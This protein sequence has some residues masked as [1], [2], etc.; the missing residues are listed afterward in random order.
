MA[1]FGGGRKRRG[2]GANA[3]HPRFGSEE[4]RAFEIST[5]K[6]GGSS[7]V[8]N[9]L[10]V[11]LR[12]NAAER[13]D[14][15]IQPVVRNNSSR[16][17]L[18]S[19]V[20]SS[21]SEIEHFDDGDSK[22]KMILAMHQKRVSSQT[23]M[24]MAPSTKKTYDESVKCIQRVVRER[25]LYKT[26]LDRNLLVERLTFERQMLGGL[27][28]LVV[29]LTIFACLML[30]VRIV[31][32]V[33]N[34]FA[35]FSNLK[36]SFDFDRIV[37]VKSPEAM[38]DLVGRVAVESKNYFP[39]S[40]IYFDEEAGG[41]VELLT[42]QEMFKQ[43]KELPIAG[44]ELWADAPAFTLLSWV[45]LD[46]RFLEGYIIR[47]HFEVK[48]DEGFRDVTC[49]GWR[50]SS[51]RGPTWS[52]GGHDYYPPCSEAD[53][54]PERD[55]TE[56][57][58]SLPEH[59]PIPT[60]SMV[61][62]GVVVRR[63][64][65]TFYMDRDELGTAPLPRELT[66]CFASSGLL[67]G[68][69]LMRLMNTRFYPYVLSK[70]MIAEVFSSGT[71]LGDL[72]TGAWPKKEEEIM[73]REGMDEFTQMQAKIAN[74][75]ASLESRLADTSP[76]RLYQTLL[77][78]EMEELVGQVVDNSLPED[79]R[80]LPDREVPVNSTLVR[81]AANDGL[82]Y[83]SLIPDTVRM[84]AS[85]A[86]EARFLSVQDTPS[87]FGTGVTF[88]FWYRHESPGGYVL[89]G[90]RGINN[91][92]MCWS[93]YIEDN[94]IYA[95]WGT[96]NT[97]PSGDKV[98]DQSY[99]WSTGVWRHIAWQFDVQDNWMRY[100][101][102]G[103]LAYQ[104][105]AK[106][107]D[108]RQLDCNPDTGGPARVVAVGHRF[109]GWTFGLTS[110]LSDVRMYTGDEAL[111]PA[112]IK[113]VAFQS[114][115]DGYVSPECVDQDE[116]RDMQWQDANSHTCMWFYH[117]NGQTVSCELAEARK[118]CPLACFS[119]QV[120]YEE[121]TAKHRTYQ[122]WDRVQLLAPTAHTDA[123]VCMADVAASDVP[124]LQERCE[125][126]VAAGGA[127]VNSTDQGWQVWRR[128]YNA[129]QGRRLNVSDCAAL[130]QAIDPFCSFERATVEEFTRAVV[131]GGG[132]YTIK[133]WV[134]PVDQDSFDPELLFA[135]Q[136]SFFSQLSPPRSHL[137]MTNI[138]GQ[139]RGCVQH[140]S[141]SDDPQDPSMTLDRC[142]EHD[143]L[144]SDMDWTFVAITFK[145]ATELE[146]SSA[147]VIINTKVHREN[148][149]TFAL[150]LY[151]PSALFTAI[152]TNYPV[153]LS[154][155]EL[156]PRVYS[157]AELQIIYYRNKDKMT[158]RLGP[159]QNDRQ[160]QLVQS[161]STKTNYPYRA[162]LLA[163][164]IIF[165]QR[166]SEQVDC[167]YSYSSDWVKSQHSTMLDEKC[168]RTV[169][170]D[171][172]VNNQFSVMSCKGPGMGKGSTYFG[173]NAT[174]FHGDVGFADLLYTIT[175][176]EYLIRNGKSIRNTTFIDGGTT[177]VEIMMV[178]FSPTL[179][180][181]TVMT[182]D[183]A[184]GV[185][186]GTQVEVQM[187]I[188]H[189]ELFGKGNDKAVY[190]GMLVFVIVLAFVLCVQVLFIFK[191]HVTV[192]RRF[193][194]LPK[195]SSLAYPTVN[196]CMY[197]GIIV[198]LATSLQVRMRQEEDVLDT[199]SS[200]DKIRWWDSQVDI[201]VK[202]DKF[203]TNI[204]YILDLIQSN[205]LRADIFNLLLCLLLVRIC[206]AT[207]THP[208]LA[209]LTETIRYSLDDLWHASLLIV[210]LMA[211]FAAIGSWRFGAD[212]EQFS[213]FEKAIQ[214]QL[215]MMLGQYFP[216]EW[217][218]KLDM[219]AYTIAYFLVIFFLIVNF[220][221][222]IIVDAYTMV[223]KQ[224]ENLKTEQEVFMDAY[225]CMRTRFYVWFYK[226]PAL[227]EVAGILSLQRAKISIGY[228]EL[229]K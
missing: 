114:S 138:W 200:L 57:H 118:Y 63:S 187:E 207:S 105:Q 150:E 40:S 49:W 161:K 52:F 64:N 10:T 102:D 116:L 117:Q 136:L 183:A 24:Q 76:L 217:N 148:S 197:F 151:D 36:A 104:E 132:D 43:P 82:L 225:S 17:Y 185:G 124:V 67:L 91:A 100:F 214:T 73:R 113:N 12:G 56:Y 80:V 25:I 211:S 22:Q 141:A 181:V 167:P 33:E 146:Q 68:S 99:W 142:V 139:V 130:A 159:K 45:E 173:L 81:D 218:S 87:F 72:S 32:R 195:L 54:C 77:L 121:P 75:G 84:T 174:R 109:P 171:E 123:T 164:P 212:N 85:A 209:L 106:G 228:S 156:S 103:E 133:F 28:Q 7:Q 35:I 14:A 158:S 177:H 2:S 160:R 50:I 210:M 149:G 165:Q 223:R 170:A 178:F 175:D 60:G 176:H 38:R 98:V 144:S 20:N 58:I 15:N 69:N 226:W 168:A 153:L 61:L 198:F 205:K 222:A 66:D 188:N 220:V 145:N 19:P 94:A 78:S 206:V 213:T 74:L 115:R 37:S 47:K 95:S 65:V 1:T 30:S 194:R 4:Q 190:Y 70:E 93:I 131:A 51:Q 83:V 110:D 191:M 154:P 224:N 27:L 44:S 129:A 120:C 203:F 41:A 11:W 193:G 26:R 108:F 112:Q 97:Y 119:Q 6:K 46:S 62:L 8:K 122:I 229:L 71:L 127:S 137:L 196:L 23:L 48:A 39:T 9:P 199:L 89:V 126:W 204:D 216:E 179:G 182:V 42:G 172:L 107:F 111:T 221:L 53:L 134:R 169:C 128:L 202:Y 79:L 55:E 21:G 3:F 29:L 143:K 162:A 5:H 215:M 59:H 125:A 135:P 101:L 88:T 180:I 34:K 140:V 155:L 186:G 90:Q 184:M 147:K 192:W 152:E 166:A 13:V 227:W 163:P 219:A 16:R 189:F 96:E 157:D 31:D 92:D 208:R 201:N 86:A 18:I